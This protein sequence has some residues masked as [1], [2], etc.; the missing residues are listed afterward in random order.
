MEDRRGTVKENLYIGAHCFLLTIELEGPPWTPLPGQFVMLRLFSKDVFLR[1]PFSIYDVENG[2]LKI[3]YRVVG[4]GTALMSRMGAG[5]RVDVLGPLGRGF[6]M[7]S[8]RPLLV[9]GG[10]GLAGLH[11][12]TK[13]RNES[14]LFFGCERKEELC[15]LQGIS[16]ETHVSTMD[17]SWGF[18]GDVISLLSSRLES[19]QVPVKIYAC[20]PKEMMKALRLLLMGREIPCEALFEERMAC[21]MGLC[22]G[23]TIET[24]DEREPFKRVCKDGPVF[25]LWDIAL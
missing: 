25:N 19:L 1:R 23:C 20:G 13:R 21:G 22:F 12:I 17:G 14:V 3:L 18:R 6:V 2:E 5:E 9:A 11:L 24:K 10:I 15:L 4:R 16:V 8:E 7:G